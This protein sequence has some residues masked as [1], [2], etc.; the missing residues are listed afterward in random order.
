MTTSFNCLTIDII[1]DMAFGEEFGS[2]DAGRLQPRLQKLFTAMKQFTFVKEILRLPWLLRVSFTTVLS[3]IM[4]RRGL[5]IKDV[6]A[7]VMV[8][9]RT[10]SE[11]ER[12]DIVSYLL[13]QDGAKNGGY[14]Y[15]PLA[16]SSGS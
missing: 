12:P 6:G 9:R 2:L 16:P 7:D 3:V 15:H 4:M 1:G 5:A 13:G 8:K 11:T 14:A 10:R